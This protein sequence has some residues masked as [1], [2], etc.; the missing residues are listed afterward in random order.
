MLIIKSKVRSVW[1]KKEWQKQVEGSGPHR[2]PAALWSWG[3]G[4]RWAKV[5]SCTHQSDLTERCRLPLSLAPRP[6]WLS[7]PANLWRPSGLPTLRTVRLVGLCVL[8][9][10]STRRA[11][12]CVCVR[13]CTLAK[14]VY[15]QSSICLVIGHRVFTLN[16]RLGLNKFGFKNVCL[17]PRELQRNPVKCLSPSS[18]VLEAAREGWKNWGRG[19]RLQTWHCASLW[20]R[21]VQGRKEEK[22]V[23]SGWRWGWRREL[24]VDDRSSKN[25]FFTIHG[26]H[27]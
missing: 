5:Q 24:Y 19:R 23:C 12:A 7:L 11:R 17:V 26:F 1:R 10:P 2:K 14:F 21:R 18:E 20:V 27:M 8:P 9:Y 3:R 6:L 25:R 4:G 13:A 16:T 22:K 15:L